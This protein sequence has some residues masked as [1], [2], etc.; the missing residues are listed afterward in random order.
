MAYHK[1]ATWL[2]THFE[3][4]TITLNSIKIEIKITEVVFPHKKSKD[5]L[6]SLEI[7]QYHQITKI[8]IESKPMCCIQSFCTGRRHLMAI[9]R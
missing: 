9:N 5:A 6:W 4:W 1:C 7:G 8:S 2:L 3:D